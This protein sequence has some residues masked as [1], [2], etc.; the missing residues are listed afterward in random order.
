[1]KIL[2][3]NPSDSAHQ[4]NFLFQKIF[5]PVPPL[6]ILYLASYLEDAKY[7]VEIFD[8]FVESGTKKNLL[9]KISVDRF[10]IV[11]FSVL[12]SSFNNSLELSKE[13]K[14]LFPDTKIIWGNIHPTLFYK[15]I[16][17]TGFVDY[18]V[19][20]E[21]E[22]VLINLLKALQLNEDLHAVDNICF[23]S[24]TEN[25]IV[26]T[27][28]KS[29]VVIMNK[30]LYPAYHLLN[31]DNYKYF[32]L[33]AIQNERFSLI[34]ASRGCPYRCY[35]CAQDIMVKKPRYRDPKL[36]VDEIQFLYEK[37]N[38]TVF[39]FSDAYFP[40]SISSGIAF[41]KEIIN[42]NLHTKIKWITET[43]I[44]QVN[45]E[46]LEIMKR[47]GLQFIMYGIESGDQRS[48][49]LINKNIEISNARHI[50]NLTK[51][52]KIITIGL[53]VIGLPWESK[54]DCK[55]TIRF[56]K[57]VNCDI[58]KFNILI[59]YPGTKYYNEYFKDQN[60]DFDSFNTW[61]N[62][63]SS[64]NTSKLKSIGKTSAEDLE[65]LQ[66]F[67]M[68]SYFLRPKIALNLIYKRIVSLQ[69]IFWGGTWLLWMIVISIISYIKP[70]RK[71]F[72]KTIKKKP[73]F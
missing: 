23:F 51:E 14:H 58:S 53:Y 5:P 33:F 47:A 26:S 70:L 35:F 61:L 69:S 46:L 48:I 10:D 8:M 72:P 56:S 63:F 41:C 9:E 40:Y 24:K 67:A 43:R 65:Q 6:S 21:G 49:N 73:T 52:S 38:I 2:L 60:L 44:D 34:S 29:N 59:P 71:V 37:F 16:I 42:R 64:S 25:K 4:N 30:V 19:K 31:L 54:E 18:I 32:P 39:I 3:V 27:K 68:V 1:M 15:E 11:G 20:G 57:K 66:R 22:L 12:T 62:T 7:S 50:V 17:E 45:K 36:V 13:I 28:N 55:E